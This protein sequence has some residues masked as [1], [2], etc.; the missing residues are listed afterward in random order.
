MTDQEQITHNVLQ[1]RLKQLTE[2]QI[3]WKLTDEN[4]DEFKVL[5]NQINDL[6]K[7]LLQYNKP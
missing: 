7:R 1:E 4:R 6:D 5:C 3:N 2:Q